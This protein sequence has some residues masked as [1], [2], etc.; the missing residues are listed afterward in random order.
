MLGDCIIH[1]P[2]II[3][4]KFEMGMGICKRMPYIEMSDYKFLLSMVQTIQNN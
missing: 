3:Q 4:V 1:K 2:D